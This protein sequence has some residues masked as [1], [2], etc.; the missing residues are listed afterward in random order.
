M[1]TIS[2]LREQLELYDQRRNTLLEELAGLKN[3]QLQKRPGPR[4]WSIL[5]IV[6]HMVLAETHVLQNL[7]EP[8]KLVDRNQGLREWLSYRIVYIVLRWNLPVPVPSED[9]TPDSHTSLLELRQKWNENLHWLRSYL[10]A[11]RPEDVKHAVFSHP[12]TGPLT[13]M[14]AGRLA[15]LHFDTHLRQIRKIMDR[16]GP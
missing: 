8:E 2:I 10:A 13:V 16:I 5:D 15:Q 1:T 14:Q 4:K 11:I 12:V 7:P 6:Q 9:M 3:D